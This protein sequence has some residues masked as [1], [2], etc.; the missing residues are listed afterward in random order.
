M[1]VLGRMNTHETA[2]HI[3]TALLRSFVPNTYDEDLYKRFGSL[4]GEM[5]IPKWDWPMIIGFSDIHDLKTA[6]ILWP[7]RTSEAGPELEIERFTI[8][9]TDE[10]ERST[11]PDRLPWFYQLGK[12]RVDQALPPS[13]LPAYEQLEPINVHADGQPI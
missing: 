3:D 6:Q 10:H 1:V 9:S 7:V 4:S 8:E 2:F 13:T 12:F 11:L 5:D